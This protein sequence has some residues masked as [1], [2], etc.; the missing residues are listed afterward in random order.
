MTI[1]RH[2]ESG[3]RSQEWNHYNNSPIWDFACSLI[4][5]YLAPLI[6]TRLLALFSNISTKTLALEQIHW[7]ISSNVWTKL[8]AFIIYFSFV[9]YIH[10]Y[11]NY[12]AF[13]GLPYTA[14]QGRQYMASLGRQYIASLGKQYIAS[15]GR[16]YMASL[17]F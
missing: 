10:S 11:I 1:K 5:D 12:T 6:S 15:L 3:I 9:P 7:I 14:S 13:V 2:I 4:G 8:L 16:Q 17:A